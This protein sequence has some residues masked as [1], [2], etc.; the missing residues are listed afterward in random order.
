M[1]VIDYQNVKFTVPLVF[2]GSVVYGMFCFLVLAKKWPKIMRRWES[3][4]S[5]MPKHR[6]QK[7]KK[8]LA[9]H[10]KILAFVVL[11]GSLG[12]ILNG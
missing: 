5:K 12:K 10:L 7:D 6:T 8:K 2:Y 4:E 11:M 9:H 3:V 1:C